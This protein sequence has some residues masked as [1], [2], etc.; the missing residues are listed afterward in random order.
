[1]KRSI[2]TWGFLAALA[3]FSAVTLGTDLCHGQAADGNIVGAVVDSQGAAIVGAEVSA[4]SVATNTVATTKTNESGEFR[5]DHL[6]VGTYRVTAKM[7]AFKTVVEESEVH[8][9]TT[10]TVNLTLPAGAVSETVEVSG[11]APIIDTTTAQLQTTYEEKQLADL[12]TTGL[13]VSPLTGQNLGVLNL[14]MLDAG[15]ASSGG[16]G[17]GTGPSVG[18]QRPRDNNY[19]IEGIDNNDKGVTGPLVY[20]PADAV[21][22]F[23]VLQNQF[24]SEF[25]HSNG[26]QFNIVVRNGT[27]SF[28][29]L[30]YEYFQNRNLNAIDQDVVNSTAPGLTPANPRF[31]NNRFG[32][33]IGG[34]IL[35]DKV[36]F[37]VNYEYGVQGLAAVPG[38]PILAPT[39][40]GYTN[41]LAIPGVSSANINALQKYAVA[42][43]ATSAVCV[44]ASVTPCPAANSIAVGILPVSAPN[45]TNFKALITS[46][47]FD[48]SDR[49]QIRGRYIYNQ[50]VGLDAFAQLPAFFTPL[51]QPYHLVNL[52][53]YHTFSPALGNEFRLG[54]T[55]TAFDD[56]VNG[57]RFLPT[58]DAFPNITITE[59]GGLDVG[60]DPNGPQYATQN[61]YQAID[62]LSWVKRNHTLKF[63]I[64]G[65]K[66]ISPQLDIQRPRGDYTYQTLQDF[67]FDQVPGFGQRGLG[68]AGY[69]G[70]QY[71]IYWYVNDIWKIRPNLSL[72][73]GVRYEYT[74]TTT[75]MKQL[76][77]D[78]V[79]DVPG[80]ITFTSPKAPRNDYMPRVGF[81]YSPGQSGDTSIRGGFGM[82]YDVLYDNIGSL[83]RPPQIGETINCPNPVCQNPFLANGGIAPG[84]FSG[85][86]TLTS[87]EAIQATSS[88]LPNNLKYPKA[89]SWNLGVQHVFAKNYTADIRYVGTRGEDLDV[90]NI[91]NFVNG[92]KNAPGYFL[93]TYI[94][95]TNQATVN[96]LPTAWAQCLPSAIQTINGLAVCNGMQT[97]TN[98]AAGAGDI[99]GTLAYGYDDV[100]TGPGGPY[101][102]RF[103]N[104]GF[105]N[106]ITAFM[107]WGSSIYH[108]LQTQLNRR[109]SNGLQFQA[110]YT[111]SHMIDNS[112]A[113]FH[114]TDISPRRPQDF[115]DLGAERANSILDHRH[116]ITIAAIYDAPWFRHDSSWVRR[117]VLGNYE[118]APVFTWESGQ[119]GTVQSGDDANLNADPAPDRAIF[120]PSGV[121]R[122][123][124]DVVALVA[125]SGPNSGNIVAY[126]AVNPNAQFIVA[127]MGALANSSRNTFTTAPINNWDLTVAKHLY[128][129]ERI[130]FDMLMQ[131]LN[132]FNH[133]EFAT[134]SVDQALPI[135]DVGSERNYFIPNQPNFGLS[136]LSFP[137]NARTLQLALRLSF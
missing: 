75:G 1:M 44:G 57:L 124:S 114:S 41:L 22:N 68:S 54:F 131:A 96:G 4:I 84:N 119:W 90:Q 81:A 27:N 103:F 36:F 5:L 45:Y 95:P 55:R 60:P 74:S 122:T 97:S 30:A 130:H 129:T 13:G 32:G 40:G 127:Q 137:S 47:D 52:S 66:S 14:S 106:P 19:T 17:A 115:Q 16:L 33:Q 65:A 34:P 72:T 56:T 134:G 73:Y 24:N 59:L 67:A 3:T 132:A 38:A 120:N 29:G 48:L 87:A 53:E 63:G 121:K 82:G 76:A 79:A 50:S 21:A 123:G 46:V 107:P 88:Y 91:L 10:G 112:T 6:L 15:V 9:N 117:N 49:D 133:P 64:E 37:F 42:P 98:G 113:D 110:A 39:S 25:G 116:R 109:F 85:I 92:A 31:D 136:K 71:S 105:V 93:P 18:G 118:I 43:T 35:K 86:A 7:T 83:A 69:S 70:D 2:F 104:A 20:V 26:G 58:L 62:N 89:L 99:P 11:A 61:L 80:L 12:P 77:L 101:D 100:G 94:Q 135:S 126:Q 28:H 128:V 111:F 108:G 78:S 51:I 23:T 8:L 125:T 102:P